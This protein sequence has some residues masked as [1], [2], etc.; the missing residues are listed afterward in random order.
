VAVL[1][2][3]RVAKAVE[4]EADAR[5]AHNPSNLRPIR[6]SHPETQELR[7]GIV[8]CW[9]TR[10]CPG[11]TWEGVLVAAVALVAAATGRASVEAE[12]RVD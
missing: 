9:R 12:V 11:R 6:T 3:V 8:H 10:T 1:A 7:P 4:A 2:V 5:E